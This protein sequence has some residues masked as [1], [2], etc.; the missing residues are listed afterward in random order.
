MEEAEKFYLQKNWIFK[1]KKSKNIT[2]LK[3]RVF[4]TPKTLVLQS[5]REKIF[6]KGNSIY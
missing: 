3:K 2:S 6:S 5:K 4:L 1:R